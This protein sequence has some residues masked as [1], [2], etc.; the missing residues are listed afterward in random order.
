MSSDPHC[1]GVLQG[2]RRD[3]GT[4]PGARGRGHKAPLNVADAL[5]MFLDDETH[6]GAVA[7]FSAPQMAEKLSV[8]R[9][10]P[11][12]LLRLR[13]ALTAEVEHPFPE[14]NVRPLARENGFLPAPSVAS[15]HEEHLERNRPVRPRPCP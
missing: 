5:A 1:G 3:L 13:R 14:I 15:D 7:R 11:A 12:A 4:E 2:M 9:T 6:V 10:A 8:E